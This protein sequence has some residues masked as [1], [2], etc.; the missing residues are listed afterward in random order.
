MRWE[1]RNNL[2]GGSVVVLRSS[3]DVN[4]PDLPNA[5]SICKLLQEYKK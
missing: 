1:H 2:V 5:F 4:A 3:D